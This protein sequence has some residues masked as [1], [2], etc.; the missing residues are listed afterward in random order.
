MSGGQTPIFGKLRRLSGRSTK[1]KPLTRKLDP[2]TR[3]PERKT[4]FFMCVFRWLFRRSRWLFRWIFGLNP[5]GI[6]T[7]WSSLGI[8]ICDYFGIRVLWFWGFSI[9]WWFYVFGW[10]WPNGFELCSLCVGFSGQWCVCSLWVVA[11]A[12]SCRDA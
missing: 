6:K 4:R 11:L 10:W 1:P 12:S 7:L 8:L 5:Q 9:N 3:R 2:V